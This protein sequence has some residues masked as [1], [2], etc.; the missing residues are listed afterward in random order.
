MAVIGRSRRVHTTGP[1]LI[2]VSPREYK[3]ARRAALN[4]LGLS[5]RQLKAQARS[6]EFASLRAR[7]LWLAIGRHT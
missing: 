5:Y 2:A 4:E 7:K 3:E 6:G 1:E